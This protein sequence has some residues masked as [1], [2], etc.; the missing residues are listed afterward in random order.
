MNIA[1]QSNGVALCEL[2]ACVLLILDQ[3]NR[4]RK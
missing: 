4:K 1:V 3:V 2:F